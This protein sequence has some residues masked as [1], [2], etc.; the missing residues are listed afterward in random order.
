MT[1]PAAAR[2]DGRTPAE[3]RPVAF[4]RNFT[5]YA[6]GSVL[7]TVGGTRVLC[8]ASVEE[9]VP[10]WLRGQGSGWVTAEYS[11]LP[12]ATINRQVRDG[13][14][15]QANA[16]NLEIQR[17]IGRSLRTVTDL[18]KLGERTIWLDCD[19]LQADGGTRTASITGAFV[20]LADALLTLRRRGALSAPPLLGQVAATSVGIWKGQPVLDLCYEEDAAAAVDLNLVMTSRGEIVEI[21][22]TGEERGFSRAE[23]GNLLDLGWDGIQQ[24]LSL[25]QEALGPDL[26]GLLQEAGART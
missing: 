18:T 9:K 13:V 7:V 2:P 5:K 3:H 4:T 21:Q 20:A 17:L 11:M 12:R 26:A 10:P 23:L 19:V 14:R 24:L 15:G 16:R 8:T 25:Q 22:G 1:V 6:E